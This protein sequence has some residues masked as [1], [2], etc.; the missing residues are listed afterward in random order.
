M[1]YSDF[2]VCRDETHSVDSSEPI[3]IS[4]GIPHPSKLLTGCFLM[5]LEMRVGSM[6]KFPTVK[7]TL[8]PMW[9]AVLM[10]GFVQ[11]VCGD[12]ASVSTSTPIGTGNRQSNTDYLGPLDSI[13]PTT[14][15]SLEVNFSNV[16]AGEAFLV[17]DIVGRDVNAAGGD[18]TWDYILNLPIDAVPG[19]GFSNITF[20][21]HA[22]ERSTNNLET[23]DEI[24]WE[25]FLNGSPV[26]V[27]SGSTGA[28]VDFTSIDINLSNSGSPTANEILV[29]M[30]VNGFDAGNEWFAA[31][32]T[33]S[34]N[35][36]TIPEPSGQALLALVTLVL[37]C[38]RRRASVSWFRA[39]LPRI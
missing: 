9:A 30:T 18:R 10:M 1:G 11:S 17:G 26:V 38:P 36:E 12:I 35:Y 20:S 37:L 33:L 8:T 24:V 16:P 15:N 27:E 5:I 21:A 6:N 32:G 14:V 3:S 2:L 7:Q 39:V 19:T 4:G 34:A 25:M 29:R 31:R 23:T 28:G 13:V 22:F